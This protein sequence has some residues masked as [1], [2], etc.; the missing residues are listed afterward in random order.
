MLKIIFLTVMQFVSQKM[1]K[2]RKSV[3]VIPYNSVFESV[4]KLLLASDE[5]PGAICCMERYRRGYRVS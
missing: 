4:E 2:Q 1:E 3:P 5:L